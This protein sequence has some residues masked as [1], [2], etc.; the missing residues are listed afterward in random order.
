MFVFICC[1]PKLMADCLAGWLS[2]NE[3]FVSYR[4]PNQ[5]NK[6]KKKNLATKCKMIPGCWWKKKK[7]K[8]IHHLSF[9]VNNK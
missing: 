6:Q 4:K 2:F 7:K 9:Q 3:V 1:L 5:T 8:K